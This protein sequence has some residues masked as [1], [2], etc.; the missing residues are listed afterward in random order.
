M[1]DIELTPLPDW[2]ECLGEVSAGHIRDYARASMEPL[3]AEIEA[4]WAELARV[5]NPDGSPNLHAEQAGAAE[6]YRVAALH[7]IQKREEAEARAERLAEALRDAS[8]ALKIAGLPGNAKNFRAIADAA[9]GQEADR[10]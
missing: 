4:L 6:S 5:T 9:L 3:I 2:M 10:G 8:D 7:A 1:T